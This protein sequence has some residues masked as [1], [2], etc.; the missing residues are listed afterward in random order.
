MTDLLNAYW[1]AGREH[2]AALRACR[3]ARR[4][5]APADVRAAL[6]DARRKAYDAVM[7]AYDALREII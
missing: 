1:D 7:R 5:G 3:D 4:A 2:D 6:R